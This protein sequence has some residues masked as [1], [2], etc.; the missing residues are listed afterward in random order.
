MGV[1]GAGPRGAGGE[2]PTGSW[3]GGRIGGPGAG[4]K[5][6]SGGVCGAFLAKIAE[7]EKLPPLEPAMRAVHGRNGVL[8][9]PPSAEALACLGERLAW[10]EA[11]THV[12]GRLL[13][14]ASSTGAT[15][16]RALPK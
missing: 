1:C 8:D 15:Q 12:W 7:R 2:G 5:G 4:G 16:A 10:A 11:F 13:G 3:V 14:S 9:A 6:S